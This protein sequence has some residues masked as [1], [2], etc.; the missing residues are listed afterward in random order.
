[1]VYAFDT[2]FDILGVRLVFG[3]VLFTMFGVMSPLVMSFP[4]MSSRVMRLE[5]DT[6]YSVQFGTLQGKLGF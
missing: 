3:G 6:K 4:V 5:S 2:R 1:L